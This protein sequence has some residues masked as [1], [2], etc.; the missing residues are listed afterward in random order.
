MGT[1]RAFAFFVFAVW[2]G[3]ES[4]HAEERVALVERLTNPVND[5]AAVARS[6][7]GA[8]FELVDLRLDLNASE[9]RHAPRDFGHRTR[10]ADVAIVYYAGRGIEVDGSNYLI[11]VDASL[12]NDNNLL[13]Q[14]ISLDRKPFAVEQAKQRR[15]HPRRMPG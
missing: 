7:K 4:A 13:E 1:L 10:D 6:S 14:T 2:I 11:P 12:E 5:A 3:C 15:R 8:G 9:M